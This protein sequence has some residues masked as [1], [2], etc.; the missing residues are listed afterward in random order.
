MKF[1]TLNLFETSLQVRQLIGDAELLYSCKVQKFNR[2]G[3]QQERIVLLTSEALI[4]LEQGPH[5][6]IEHRKVA[7]SKIAGF[8]IS[9]DSSSQEL[10]LHISDDYDERYNCETAGHK[11]NL[12]NVVESLV[13]DYLWYIVPDKKLRKYATTKKDASA[14]Q[15]KRP[16]E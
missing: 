8:T 1:D 2:Y 4:T 13:K 11:L 5:N 16:D 6:Y 15:V 10:V 3:F 7:M 14:M 12:I 9:S